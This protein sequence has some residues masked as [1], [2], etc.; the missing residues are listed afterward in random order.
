M[1]KK[2]ATLAY[3]V[4]L[5]FTF[6]TISI[7]TIRAQEQLEVDDPEFVLIINSLPELMNLRF[8]LISVLEDIQIIQKNLEAKDRSENLNIAFRNKNVELKDRSEDLNIALRTIAQ[9]ARMKLLG[10]EGVLGRINIINQQINLALNKIRINTPKSRQ[11]VKEKTAIYKFLGANFQYLINEI[12]NVSNETE[13]FDDINF[14]TVIARLQKLDPNRSNPE[15]SQA[16]DY[17]IDADQEAESNV[18]LNA[19]LLQKNFEEYEALLAPIIPAKPISGLEGD[20]NGDN[21]VNIFD[22]VIVARNFGKK[23]VQ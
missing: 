4:L 6:F 9:G 17:L 2:R 12:Y 11:L 7:F 21:Q 13:Y 22:L 20:L 19:R 23:L 10:E 8:R 3:C 1:N 16:L 14:N 18:M 5:V 15:I